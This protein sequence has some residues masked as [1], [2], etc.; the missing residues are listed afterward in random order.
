MIVSARAVDGPGPAPRRALARV[1][2]PNG[3]HEGVPEW[4]ASLA[5][6]VH[7][8]KRHRYRRNRTTT[9]A[10]ATRVPLTVRNVI[11]SPW[12]RAESRMVSTG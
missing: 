3:G 10:T 12:N 8:P 7:S 11:L 4:R 1:T 5:A 9:P 2:F 6:R